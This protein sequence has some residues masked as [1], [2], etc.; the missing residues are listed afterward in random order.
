MGLQ[1]GNRTVPLNFAC[2]SFG[3]L[4]SAWARD[5]AGIYLGPETMHPAGPVSEPHFSHLAPCLVRLS[6]RRRAACFRSRRTPLLVNQVA[7]VHHARLACL[8][9]AG[10]G[11][12]RVVPIGAGR[13]LVALIRAAPEMGA[14]LPLPGTDQPTAGC[15]PKT[16]RVTRRSSW[17]S[18]SPQAWCSIWRWPRAPRSWPA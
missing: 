18:P 12:C 8:T 13:Y 16:R 14:R 10:P 1:S 17:A 5:I 4:F 11:F 9:P 3:I 6:G 15:G 2:A 7:L